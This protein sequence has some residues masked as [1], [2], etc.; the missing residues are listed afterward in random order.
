MKKLFSIAI[1]IVLVAAIPLTAFA[2]KYSDLNWRYPLST[3]YTEYYRGYS[4]ST[5]HWGFDFKAPKDATIYSAD[6]GTCIYAGFYS[7]T[8]YYVVISHTAK[9]TGVTNP[10]YVRY[11]H[12]DNSPS[13]KTSDSITRGK[14][15]GYVG[16]TGAYIGSKAVNHLH[17]DVNTGKLT[18]GSTFSSTNTIDPA[19]FYPDVDFV[20]VSASPTR[21]GEID[22]C[23]HEE[24]TFDI[25]GYIDGYL[26]EYVGADNF[27]NWMKANSGQVDLEGFLAEF[28]I[29][30]EE[31][32]NLTAEFGLEEIY[33]EVLDEILER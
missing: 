10:L 5:P 7:D 8:G 11:L 25:S 32:E 22:T 24:G 26:I 17:M 20:K 14:V 29:S 16:S 15:L 3:S 18:G 13:V 9:L 6:A 27:D 19:L 23:E 33:E 1:A 21:G 30:E 4:T 28:N 2:D 31:F 12:M